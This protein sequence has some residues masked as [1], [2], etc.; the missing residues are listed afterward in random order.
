MCPWPERRFPRPFDARAT[1]EAARLQERFGQ[2]EARIQRELESWQAANPRPIAPLSAVADHIEHIRHVAGID[3]V[4]FGS[5]FDGIPTYVEGLGDVSTFPALLVELARRRWSDADLR[6]LAGENIL[7][8]MREAEATATPAI[9]TT[10][11]NEVRGTARGGSLAVRAHP[12]P[13]PDR[14]LSVS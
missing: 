11:D 4:G 6:K 14:T 1:K 2:D 3:H 13:F 8:V 12:S 10:V 7:R 5:D 9:A